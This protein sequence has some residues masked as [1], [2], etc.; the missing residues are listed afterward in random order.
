M[1][2]NRKCPQLL[3]RYSAKD[4]FERTDTKDRQGWHFTYPPLQ[5]EWDN[6]EPI[7]GTPVVDEADKEDEEREIFGETLDEPI[8][9]DLWAMISSL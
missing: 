7:E 8:P 3:V 5:N 9:D 1:W 6:L 2:R 4:G